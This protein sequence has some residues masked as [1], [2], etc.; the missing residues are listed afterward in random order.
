ME[1]FLRNYN[2]IL[3]LPCICLSLYVIDNMQKMYRIDILFIFPNMF[4]IFPN[5]TYKFVT[6]WQDSKSSLDLKVYFLQ[7]SIALWNQHAKIAWQLLR[8]KFVHFL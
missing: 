7:S 5:K 4:F 6:T 8:I 2:L 3:Q 1:L